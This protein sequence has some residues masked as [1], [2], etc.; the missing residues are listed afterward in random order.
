MILGTREI[1]KTIVG[2]FDCITELCD[3]APL[4]I[5]GSHGSAE[6][7][8]SMALRLSLYRVKYEGGTSG[9]SS[10]D[11]Q[12]S[13]CFR[14]WYGRPPLLEARRCLLGWDQRSL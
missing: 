2:D 12:D 3:G 8:S 13:A 4:G 5:L 10:R 6:E 1:A 7:A 9:K 11:V 14:F